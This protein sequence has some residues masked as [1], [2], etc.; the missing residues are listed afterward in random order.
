MSVSSQLD[1][2]VGINGL[3][4]SSSVFSI[5]TTSTTITGSATS[6]TLNVPLGGLTS[7]MVG[8]CVIFTDKSAATITDLQN[9]FTAQISTTL[10]QDTQ[11]IRVMWGG[12]QFCNSGFGA[13]FISTNTLSAVNLTIEILNVAGDL[14]IGGSLSVTG[15]TFLNSGLTVAGSTTMNNNLDI[16]GSLSTTGSADIGSNCNIGGD[17]LIG[18][19]VIGTGTA[20]FSGNIVSLARIVAQDQLEGTSCLIGTGGLTCFGPQSVYGNVTNTGLTTLANTIVSGN[21]T[22]NNGIVSNGTIAVTGGNF[23]TTDGNFVTSNGSVQANVGQFN[24]LTVNGT[25]NF[26]N[27]L[28][29]VGGLITYNGVGLTQLVPGTPGQFLMADP[30]SPYGLRW[31]T[32]NFAT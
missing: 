14:S 22:A 23:S 32:L 24:T 21:L 12:T 15:D 30:T 2:N 18:G 7:D 4:R 10:P 13:P 19:N 26:P 25:I 31:V 5:G 17:T 11:Q 20:Q 9:E 6:G 3:V 29:T 28:N 1:Y 8:G 27:I 16:T